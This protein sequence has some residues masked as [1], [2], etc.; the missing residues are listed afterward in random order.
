MEY[1][2]PKCGGCDVQRQALEYYDLCYCSDCGYV[3]SPYEF[4]PEVGGE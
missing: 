4:I 1:E 3:D 2:C